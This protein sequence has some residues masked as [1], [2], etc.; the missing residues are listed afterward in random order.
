MRK[1]MRPTELKGRS[2]GF[3]KKTAQ[4]LGLEEPSRQFLHFVRKTTAKK[5]KIWTIKELLK[6]DLTRGKITNRYGINDRWAKNLKV[7]HSFLGTIYTKEEVDAVISVMSQEVL[8][9]GQQTTAFQ[10]EFAE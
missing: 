6:A 1:H 3:A 5:K 8:S 2:F 4:R 10:K 7:P 9:S